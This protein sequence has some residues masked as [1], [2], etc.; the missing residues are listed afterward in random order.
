MLRKKASL[1]SFRKD[2]K[3]ISPAISTVI[4]TSAIVTLLLVTI[5]FANNFL[6]ARLAENEFTAMKQFTQTV[7][8]QVD[9][10]AWT[11]GRTQT[12][13]YASKYGQVK[14]ESLALVYNVQV[15]T[16]SG[17]TSLVN[18]SVG[19][20]LFNMPVSKYSIGNNYH[21]RIFPSADRSFIQ[22]GT[23]APVCHVFVIE[24]LPMDDGSFIRIVVAPTLRM[25]N[26]TISTEGEVKNY[27]KLYLPDL[28]PPLLH[29]MLSQSVTL[30][31]KNVT[32]ARMGNVDAIRVTV[33]FP[34]AG[35][36]FDSSFF[37]FESATE[38]VDIPDGSIV[39]FYSGEV[40][41]TV[42]AHL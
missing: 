20:L 12:V 15:N 7:A 28:S 10:V 36:G 21:E 8:L 37:N 3:A 4:L 32:V 33:S 11:I 5:V 23:S 29:P 13:R 14:F 40:T 19:I 18:Y 39:E 35:L 42:G 34:N 25:L 27:F 41:V 38:N 6:D 17:Y 16:G 24:K 30:T 26:A 22:M 9:D 2:R 31:G 1:H